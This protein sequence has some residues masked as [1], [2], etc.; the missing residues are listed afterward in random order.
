MKN[1][2]V[3]ACI[4]MEACL[5]GNVGQYSTYTLG[6]TQKSVRC[7]VLDLFLTLLCIHGIFLDIVLHRGEK[8]EHVNK[9]VHSL[10][11]LANSSAILPD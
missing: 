9:S 6:K 3:M 5:I 11:V 4:R 1:L 2:E 8:V 7:V 10:Q